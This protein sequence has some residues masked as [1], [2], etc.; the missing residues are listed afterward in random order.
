MRDTAHD[1]SGFSLIECPECRDKPLFLPL[2]DNGNGDVKASFLECYTD[3]FAGRRVHIMRA[4]DSHANRGMNKVANAFLKSDCDIWINIDADILFTR[5]DIDNLLS[6]GSTQL[7][8]GIYPKKSDATE[9]CLCTF[10]TVEPS[11]AESLV[12]VRRA[13]RGFMLVR[14]ELLEAM[15]EDNGGPAL[16]YHNHGEIEWDF[17][18]SGPVTGELSALSGKDEDGYPMREWISEDWYFC[19][20]ARALGVPTWMDDRIALG[21]EGSK[22]YRFGVDQITRTDTNITSWKE[23]H[24]W[25]DYEELYREIADAIP[26]GGKFVEVGCWMGRSL[27]AFREFS[28]GKQLEIHAVDTFGGTPANATHAAILR[29]HGGNVCETF[30]GNMRALGLNGEL[31]IHKKD[32]AEAA[33]DF[34]GGSVDAVFIDADHSYEA[35]KRDILA[36]LPKVKGGGMIC[37]HDFDEP[38]VKQA[39]VEVFGHPVQIGRCWKVVLL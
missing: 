9:P 15:K 3:A 34:E 31:T 23:I 2:L 13:G 24:G 25:F 30:L 33:D 37:G 6:H 22:Q 12:K 29:A 19:E 16:R 36:W 35:V 17:F 4:S 10:E 8:Y 5:K 32:S 18:P 38:G 28:K 21:H 1:E 26:E 20:R 11:N 7:V 27:G 14:R 39:V